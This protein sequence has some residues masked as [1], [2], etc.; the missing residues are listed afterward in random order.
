MHS[1]W[2]SVDLT[3]Y[4]LQ[5]ILALYEVKVKTIVFDFSIADVSV[6]EEKLLKPLS[7]LEIGVLGWF[8]LVWNF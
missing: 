2:P 8:F 7:D 5:E 6:Y 1:N 4:W 3:L